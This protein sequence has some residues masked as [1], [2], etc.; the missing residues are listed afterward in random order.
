[1]ALKTLT[2][3]RM[4]GEIC[5]LHPEFE[6]LRNKHLSVCVECKWIKAKE[7]RETA[8]GLASYNKARAKYRKS[9]GW[10]DSA[11]ARNRACYRKDPSKATARVVSRNLAKEQRV[12]S[13]AD[14]D[15]IKEIYRQAQSKGLVVDHVI[16]LRG[17]LVSGLHVHNNLQ[18]LTQEE[19]DKK[20]NKY[21]TS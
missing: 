15:K 7:Y 2:P 18:L 4:Y 12:P 9:E 17:K 19:N 1:M 3:S 5:P 14:H 10:S 8:A 21:E 11:N 16:P 20:G 13:W 6:G